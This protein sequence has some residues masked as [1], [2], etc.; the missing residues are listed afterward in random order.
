MVDPSPVSFYQYL[1][2]AVSWDSQRTASKGSQ[3]PIGPLYAGSGPCRNG[4]IRGGAI[5]RSSIMATYSA[6]IPAAGSGV[7]LRPFT[8]TRPK[9]LVYVA[10]KPIM[11]H[12]LDGLVG[13]VDQV[14]VIVGYMADKVE[15]Y[16]QEA[17]GDQVTFRFVH[18]E[19]LRR[20]APKVRRMRTAIPDQGQIFSPAFPIAVVRHINPP[21]RDTPKPGD[22]G[23]CIG[24]S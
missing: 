13:E 16:C 1:N 7:R 6:L 15:T 11:G 4:Q 3:T 14:T 10:G 19:S 18:Q 5:P 24:L 8:F 23:W 21:R 12:I 22:S 9:P 20:V 2:Y 17:Y